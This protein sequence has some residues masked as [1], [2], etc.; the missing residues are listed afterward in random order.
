MIAG[1][2][3]ILYISG[4]RDVPVAPLKDAAVHLYDDAEKQLNN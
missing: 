2:G 3:L 4:E 1:G